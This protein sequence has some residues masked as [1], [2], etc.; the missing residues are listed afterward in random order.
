VSSAAPS[1][2]ERRTGSK[3]PVLRLLCF[4]YAGGGASAFR[5]WSAHLPADV[6][7]CAIELP[8]RE[9]RLREPA[10]ASLPALIE[11]LL[12]ETAPLRTGRFALFGHSL[13]ALVAFEL[14]RALRRRGEA[15]PVSLFVSGC[16]APQLG[17]E[18][19]TPVGELDE[20]AFLALL[21]EFAGTPEAVLRD[22]ELLSLLLPTLRADFGLRD[23]YVCGDEPGLPLPIV[24]FGGEDDAHVPI[25][26]LFD[27]RAQTQRSFALSRFAGR[28]FYFR[29]Q[30]AFFEAFAGALNRLTR[31]SRGEQHQMQEERD[32]TRG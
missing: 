11:L 21:R 12:A 8:G 31:R 22:R 16:R 1:A 5:D 10:I 29:D 25:S 27:W 20:P 4:P 18:C 14:A 19:E 17:R 13:G 23:G 3:P 2:Q 9:T 28:H 6:E 24:A 7:L 26:S 32:G 30:P 15:L